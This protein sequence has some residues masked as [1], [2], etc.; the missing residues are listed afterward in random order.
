MWANRFIQYIVLLSIFGLVSEARADPILLVEIHKHGF[1]ASAPGGPAT[2]QFVTEITDHTTQTVFGGMYSG[3]DEGMTFDAPAN[4]V[5][6]FEIALSAETG[7]F[8]LTDG[9]HTP[10]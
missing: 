8:W 10:T 6:A 4:L 2:L 9:S 5:D 1:P 7:R 3:A